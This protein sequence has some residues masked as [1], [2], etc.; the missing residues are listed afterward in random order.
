MTENYGDKFET[1]L[2][3]ILSLV[4]VGALVGVIVLMHANRPDCL[5]ANYTYCGGQN[6]NY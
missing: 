4:V 5:S 1:P 2:E 6:V 3:I